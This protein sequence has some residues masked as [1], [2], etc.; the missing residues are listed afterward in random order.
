M[1]VVNPT[2]NTSYPAVSAS[3]S[4]ARRDVCELARRSGA[5]PEELDAV[6][7]AVSEAVT[8]VVRHAYRDDSGTVQLTAAAAGGELWVLVAD[9]GDGME[10][11]TPYPGLG[12][13]LAL[14]SQMAD[15]VT[16]HHR[17]TGGVELRMRFDLE[18]RRDTRPA[19]RD[20]LAE[21]RAQPR[22]SLASARSPASP[23]FST[24]R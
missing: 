5:S 12:V 13:G 2:L 4:R 8:N 22:G 24:T 9:D 1:N 16:I 17:G 11:R 10:V 6:R 14:I 20:E 23:R 18:T 7:L 15:H 21:R 19:P 3:V